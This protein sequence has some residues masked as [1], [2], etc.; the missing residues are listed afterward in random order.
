MVEL[1][2]KL[3]V[4]DEVTF[5]AL[6]AIERLGRLAVE[7][8]ETQ[9]VEDTYVDTADL[10]LRRAGFG[11]RLRVAGDRVTAGLKGMGGVDGDIH[12]RVELEH[13]LDGPTVAALLRLAEE[14]G[15][16]VRRLAGG[17]PLRPLFVLR[18]E[19]QRWRVAGGRGGELQMSLDRSRIEATTGET[20]LLEVELELVSGSQA[21]LEQAARELRRRYGLEPSPLSKFERGLA[22]AGL[23]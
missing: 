3:L 4:P 19:R 12:E 5:A 6:G 23:V 15:P 16:M 17:E 20:E 10:R 2:A 9:V 21:L 13:A 1:E 14:P 18:T 7:P 22:L 11:C 8:R